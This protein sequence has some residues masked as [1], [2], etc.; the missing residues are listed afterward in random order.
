MPQATTPKI[1][2]Q[3]VAGVLRRAGFERHEI[4]RT[5]GGFRV[6]KLHTIG[7][8]GVYVDWRGSSARYEAVQAALEAAGYVVADARPAATFK[9]TLPLPDAPQIHDHRIVDQPY[10]V[11]RRDREHEA[12]KFSA[13]TPR[14][15]LTLRLFRDTDAHGNDAWTCHPS[16]QSRFA[17]DAFEADNAHAAAAGCLGRIDPAAAKPAHVAQALAEEIVKARSE[18]MPAAESALWS[19]VMRLGIEVDVQGRIGDLH[20]R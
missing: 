11:D 15:K 4:H 9:V 2:H 6:R 3:A 12:Y 7:H 17:L 13:L 20:D 16:H 18:R 1:T 5:R 19:V 14:G 10:R 8:D